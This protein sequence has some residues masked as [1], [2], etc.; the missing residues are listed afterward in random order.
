MAGCGVKR[1]GKYADGLV[2]RYGALMGNRQAQ[3]DAAAD[4]PAVRA[5]APIRVVSAAPAG[6]GQG[7]YRPDPSFNYEAA[8]RAND[9]ALAAARAQT[10]AT[11]PLDEAA[12]M[13]RSRQLV[14]G[15]ADGAVIPGHDTK[16]SDDVPVNVTR[17]EAILPVKTVDALGGPMQVSDMIHATNGKPPAGVRRGGKFADGAAPD[18][19][20][21]VSLSGMADAAKK[22][23]AP[24]MPTPGSGM[25]TVD[26]GGAFAPGAGARPLS[27]TT[28]AP[29]QN[30]GNEGRSVPAPATMTPEQAN[31]NVLAG[32]QGNF[33]GGS[34]RPDFA[35]NAVTPVP[36]S[37]A[38]VPK[39]TSPVPDSGFVGAP[40]STPAV[41]GIRRPVPSVDTAIPVGTG[42]ITN[43]QTGATTAVG[44]PPAPP[45]VAAAPTG[46]QTLADR[47]QAYVDKT[48]P[49]S[50]PE[51]RAQAWNNFIKAETAS[52]TM[53]VQTAQTEELGQ[54]QQQQQ[55]LLDIQNEMAKPDITPQRLLQLRESLANLTGRELYKPMATVDAMGNPTTLFNTQ[56][57]QTLT[58]GG[59]SQAASTPAQAGAPT[60]KSMAEAQA[61][62]AA[63]K[64]K[65]GDIINTPNGPIRIH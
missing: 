43:N 48:A 39:V 49:N 55:H 25:R 32:G 57:G 17:G 37:T 23:I 62:K 7:I 64:I 44:K 54:K 63:G 1:G 51:A 52:S 16:G 65:S 31:A 9:A 21:Q 30:Y 22:I 33:R 20:A 42:F 46:S 13:A 15:H 28:S 45:T 61:A 12:I 47:A 26:V 36:A 3:I 40:A 29:N 50:T 8:T 10:A 18:N 41:G 24:F 6:S 60:F 35:A 11:A 58:P 4:G 27:I 38:N 2:Q 53:G 19:Y 59:G 5:S 34:I 14:P 56:T